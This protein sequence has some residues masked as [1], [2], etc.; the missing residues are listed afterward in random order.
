MPRNYKPRKSSTPQDKVAGIKDMLAKSKEPVSRVQM[1]A[2]LGFTVSTAYRLVKCLELTNEVH[3]A[4][5]KVHYTGGAPEHFYAAGPAPE[6]FEPTILTVSE[7]VLA[8][9]KLRRQQKMRVYNREAKQRQRDRERAAKL[10]EIGV[11]NVSEKDIDWVD[12]NFKYKPSPCAASAVDLMAAWNPA[13]AN[14]VNGG[15]NAQTTS[16]NQA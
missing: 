8:K 5:Y 7:E 9:R 11:V 2:K 15:Q 16:D 10:A 3:L 4:M 14:H 12:P 1:A 6:G 13:F